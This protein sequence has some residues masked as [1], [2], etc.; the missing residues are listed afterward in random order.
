MNFRTCLLYLPM[1]LI[2]FIQCKSNKMKTNTEQKST[3]EIGVPIRIGPENLSSCYSYYNTSPESP[4]GKTI[5]YIKILSEQ[6]QRYDLMTGELWMCNADLTG[7]K[8]ITDLTNF[9]THNGVN[10]QWID[11]NVIAYTIEGH[12][13]IIDL[14]GKEITTPFKVFSIGHDAYHNKI[15]YSAISDETKLYT[16]YEYDVAKNEH[17]QIADASTF[18]DIVDKFSI[19]EIIEMKDRKIRHLMYSPDGLKIAFRIDVGDKGEMGNHLVTMNKNG[20]DIHYFGPKPMHFAW[21]DNASIMGHDNQIEDGLPND[22]SARRWS[23]DTEYIETLAG[24][25]N[26]LAASSN[27]SLIASESWYKEFPVIL[28]VFR[29]GETKAF[30]EDNVST[31]GTS[32]W[33]LGNHVNPAFS[34]DGKRVYYRKTS[35]TGLSQAYMVILPST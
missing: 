20:G 29:K 21:Y 5:L 24:P 32:V 8:K 18:K 3:L 6:T 34:R 11:N 26:H 9:N 27:R 10:A 4:D 15:L 14:D 13:Q 17:I 1:V 22:K 19:S 25:G 30:W 31:D 2:A 23:L 7:H 33:K 16:I 12:I 28:R 35:A